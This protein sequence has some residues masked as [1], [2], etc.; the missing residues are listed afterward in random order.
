MRTIII[1]FFLLSA[2]ISVSYAAE[3]AV[4]RHRLPAQIPTGAY[5]GLSSKKISHP[6]NMRWFAE[7]YALAVHRAL[8]ARGLDVAEFKVDPATC[9]FSANFAT[10]HIGKALRS[11][12]NSRVAERSDALPMTNHLYLRGSI[13]GRP[14][15][16]AGVILE[17]ETEVAINA[18]MTKAYSESFR[19]RV[20]QDLLISEIRV[21]FD[22][23]ASEML[24]DGV[25]L[26]ECRS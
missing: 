25:K 14:L 20:M 16:Q 19:H 18:E 24:G 8:G 9:F 26:P 23:A 15:G 13:Q 3:I 12:Y 22:R 17:F 2:V 5:G 6:V 11:A 21:E 10:T 1:I 7:A 4:S